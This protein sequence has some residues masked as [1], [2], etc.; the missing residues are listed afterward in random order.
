M[1]ADIQSALLIQG[2]ET[3]YETSTSDTEEPWTVFYE[4]NGGNDFVVHV[5][6]TKGRYLI[7]WPDNTH[8]RTF[9]CANM[10]EILSR[11]WRQHANAVN[12]LRR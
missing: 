10:A 8:T 1:L 7:L 12:L 5:A 9:Y 6:R 2:I 11:G 3:I 4:T